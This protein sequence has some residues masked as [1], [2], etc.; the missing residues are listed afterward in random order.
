MGATD[1]TVEAEAT[2]PVRNP[3]IPDELICE[4][5]GIV[6]VAVIVTWLG[7][8]DN[9]RMCGACYLSTAT[10]IVLSMAENADA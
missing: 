5:C 8:A 2:A 6:P 1:T 10:S 3:E 4:I 7:S 9:S